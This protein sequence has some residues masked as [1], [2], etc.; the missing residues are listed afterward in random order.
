MYLGTWFPAGRWR[1]ISLSVSDLA[2]QGGYPAAGFQRMKRMVLEHLSEWQHS[3]WLMQDN[4]SFPTV[5]ASH[6]VWSCSLLDK[7][8]VNLRLIF[9]AKFNTFFNIAGWQ[10]VIHEARSKNRRSVS[11]GNIIAQFSVSDWGESNFF[12]SCQFFHSA[13]GS[14]S[15]TEIDFNICKSQ[16]CTNKSKMSKQKKQQC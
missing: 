10:L 4:H 15:V 13:G 1:W 16:T 7:S 12:R 14:Q 6:N 5:P 8:F 9:V 2:C 11:D 3:N